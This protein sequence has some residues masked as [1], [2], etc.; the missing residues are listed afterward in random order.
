MGS[1]GQVKSNQLK[2]PP[3][4]GLI[5]STL[6]RIRPLVVVLSTKKSTSA[7]TLTNIAKALLSTAVWFR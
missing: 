5:E 6:N 2:S 1:D 4:C 3:P 7:A